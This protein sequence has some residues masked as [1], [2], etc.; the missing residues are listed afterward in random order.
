MPPETDLRY[1]LVQKE[2]MYH[3]NDYACKMVFRMIV[4]NQKRNQFSNT[5]KN[6]HPRTFDQRTAISFKQTP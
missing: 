5:S 4:L 6:T 2:M 1:F 3:L